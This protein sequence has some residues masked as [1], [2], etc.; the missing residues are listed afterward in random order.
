MI[1]EEVGHRWKFDEKFI[2][3][4]SKVRNKVRLGYCI[5]YEFQIKKKKKKFL[6]ETNI[7]TRSF[8]IDYKFFRVFLLRKNSMLDTIIEIGI[9]KKFFL[10]RRISCKSDENEL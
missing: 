7:A 1:S 9:L 8:Q 10:S 2:K 3:D 6:I 4:T 5:L